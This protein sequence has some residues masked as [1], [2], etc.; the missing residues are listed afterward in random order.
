MS[1]TKQE[2]TAIVAEIMQG[3]HSVERMI[4]IVCVNMMILKD[5]AYKS[6]YSDAWARKEKRA[7]SKKARKRK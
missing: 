5:R 2:A 3:Y 1:D 4:E 6:G 7:A